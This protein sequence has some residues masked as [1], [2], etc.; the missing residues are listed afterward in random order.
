MHT[1]NN[2]Q[3]LLLEAALFIKFPHLVPSI[4]E[5]F[6]EHSTHHQCH[7]TTHH[8]CKHWR[9]TTHSIYAL[10]FICT[11]SNSRDCITY[12]AMQRQPRQEHQPAWVI[13]APDLADRTQTPMSTQHAAGMHVQERDYWHHSKLKEWIDWCHKVISPRSHR[14]LGSR[15]SHWYSPVGCRRE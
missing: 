3:W 15:G 10:P 14:E 7:H 8:C 12:T 1:L 11:V 4:T 13:S 9:R 2:G 5:I 6:N